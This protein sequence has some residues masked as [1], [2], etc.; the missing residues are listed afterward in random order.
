MRAQSLVTCER[1]ERKLIKDPDFE[2]TRAQRGTAGATSFLP[3]RASATSLPV[4]ES[5]DLDLRS[6]PGFPVSEEVR[7]SHPIP[8]L[9][10]H[11]V[12]CS[13]FVCAYAH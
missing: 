2:G 13:I 7:W 10:Q 6:Q 3:A 8:L 9:E 4:R 1:P 11:L 5:V 12:I